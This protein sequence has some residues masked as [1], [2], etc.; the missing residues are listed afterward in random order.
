MKQHVFP[1]HHIHGHMSEAHAIL[2]EV[3]DGVHW[4]DHLVH[5]QKLLGILQVPLRQVHVGARVDGS[6]LWGTKR[7]SRLIEAE[8]AESE[9]IDD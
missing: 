9:K 3:G 6:T 2:H 1:L 4:L 8:R 5:E 7:T